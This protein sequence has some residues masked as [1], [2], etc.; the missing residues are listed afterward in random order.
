MKT[1]SVLLIHAADNHSPFCCSQFA[2]YFDNQQKMQLAQYSKQ[3][4]LILT[5]KELS[6]LTIRYII[7]LFFIF[8]SVK[9][10]GPTTWGFLLPWFSAFCFLLTHAYYIYE[11]R[12]NLERLPGYKKYQNPL[13]EYGQIWRLSEQQPNAQG[14]IKKLVITR[15]LAI[16]SGLFFAAQVILGLALEK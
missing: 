13:W 5:S 2:A 6:S 15:R 11:G 14:Y 12:D 3:I 4:K 1:L 10:F 16:F 8:V 9:A 7:I